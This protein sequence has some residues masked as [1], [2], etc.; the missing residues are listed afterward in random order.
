MNNN[1]TPN[2]TEQQL[3]QNID[4][5]QAKGVPN[6]QVQSYVNNYQKSNSG[7]SLKGSTQTPQQPVQDKGFIGDLGSGN[8]LGAAKNAGN[9]LFPGVKDV[10]NDVTGQNTGANAKTPLQQTGDIALSILP[11]IPGLG[12]AGEAVR[13]AGA[14]VEGAADVAKAG[15]VAAD[16]AKSTGLM[17][18]ILGSPITKGAGV[19]Y[20]AGVASG[21]SQGKSVGQALTPNLTNVGGAL[22]GGAI[23]GFGKLLGALGDKISF[24]V[25]KPSAADIKDGFSIDT[26]KNN[27][28]G[29]SLNKTLEKTKS[30]MSDLSSQLKT[31]LAG[32]NSSIDLAGVFDKTT[33]DLTSQS[34]SLSNF[35]QNSGISRSLQKLQDEVLTANPTGALS[36]PDAQTVKQAAG[37]MGAWQ[38]GS[39]DPD[40]TAMETVYNKFYNNLKTAIEQNSPAGV[41]EINSKL[42]DLIPVMNAVIRRIPIAERNSAISLPDMIGLVG[43][44]MNPLASIP[45]AAEMASK[46]G[47]VGRLLSQ[48]GSKVSSLSPATSVGVSRLLS[49][50]L[51]GKPK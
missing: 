28:L 47:T 37:G 8:F 11:F 29:G 3:R 24:G 4:A 2:L 49:S 31:K 18:K 5:L 50:G 1:L 9:F 7:Y 17:G 27:D 45:T 30:L 13:G 46:S 35:G 15:E 26:I 33:K 41:K 21:L 10:Y 6:D 42:S 22:T 19:G 23:G 44:V 25:I 40:A 36:I 39:A 48:Y 16:T 20:G 43:S 14:A 32:S 51:M 34:G 38:Y 12:E